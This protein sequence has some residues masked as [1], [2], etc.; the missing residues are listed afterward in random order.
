MPA[1]KRDYRKLYPMGTRGSV[2]IE[3]ETDEPQTKARGKQFAKIV[4]DTLTEARALVE[5]RLEEAGF[6]DVRVW[7]DTGQSSIDYWFDAAVAVDIQAMRNAAA[8][9]T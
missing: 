2:A 5:Q 4:G 7:V 1:I 6:A 9:V 8:T 3:A